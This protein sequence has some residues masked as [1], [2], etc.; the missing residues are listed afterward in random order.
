M[1]HLFRLLAVTGLLAIAACGPFGRAPSEPGK[2]PTTQFPGMTLPD[3]PPIAEQTVRP[4]APLVKVALLLPLSGESAQLGSAM[5]DAAMLALNDKYLALPAEKQTA[6]LVVLPKDTGNS[7]AS[8]EAAAREAIDE[9]ATL[10]LGPLFSKSASA[11]G[12][13]AKRSNVN[14]VTFSNNTDVASSNVFVFGFIPDQQVERIAEYAG[15]KG[16]RHFAAIG[17][18]D[19]YGQKVTQIFA[20]QITKYGAT[21]DPVELYIPYTDNLDTSGARLAS[22]FNDT[23]ESLRYEALFIPEGGTQLDKITQML[24]RHQIDRSK[25]RLLGTG[26]WD[27]NDIKQ[28]PDLIGG[29]FASSPPQTVQW[30]EKRF[31]AAYKYQPQR[32]AGLAYDAVALAAAM[33]LA[34]S[35]PSFSAFAITDP[36]GY[37]GPAN[38]LFRFRTDGTSERGLAVMEITSSGFK[39]LDPA[40]KSF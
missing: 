39:T 17:P 23:E 11:I 3:T 22:A 24:R 18:N 30:F 1:K 9:G 7:I 5:L 27:E 32:L 19:A 26:Q 16:L 29:W 20:R 15:Q 10:I 13:I 8:A 4:D 21:L 12:T 35:G 34:P 38:G 33:A 25:L 37:S 28:S 36:R 31:M 40:P 2:A 14:V 6:Q